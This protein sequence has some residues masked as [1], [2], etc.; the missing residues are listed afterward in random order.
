MQKYTRLQ[1]Y[2]II[3]SVTKLAPNVK[4]SENSTFH[5]L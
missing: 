2:F 4:I 5:L 3:K 1:V